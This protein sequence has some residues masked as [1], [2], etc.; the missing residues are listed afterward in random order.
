MISKLK[1]VRLKKEI[2]QEELALI[3]GYS[4]AFISLVESGKREPS[5]E[6]LLVFAEALNCTVT[7]LYSGGLKKVLLTEI[8]DEIRTLSEIELDKAID[9]IRLL[10][11]GRR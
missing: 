3:T 11:K 1:L 9:Y 4:Q 6:N 5:Q 8:R 2:N 10:K 7:E